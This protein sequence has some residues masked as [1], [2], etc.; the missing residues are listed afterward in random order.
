MAPIANATTIR[1][2]DTPDMGAH[3]GG[4]QMDLAI[5]EKVPRRP[6]ALREQKKQEAATCPTSV[7][8]A[9]HPPGH[10]SGGKLHIVLK[11]RWRSS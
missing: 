7:R 5:F 3:L 8:R 9:M 4:R 10:L 2:A 1:F 6:P 11:R